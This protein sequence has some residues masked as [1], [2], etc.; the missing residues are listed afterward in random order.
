MVEA[1]LGDCNNQVVRMDKPQTWRKLLGNCI[2]DPHERQRIASELGVNP[3]TLTRWVKHETDPHPQTL[4]RLLTVLPEHRNLLLELINKEFAGFS[5]VMRDTV[6]RSEMTSIPSE[7]Y[8]R[9]LHTLTSTPK[10]LL[11]QVLCTMLLE[12]ALKH[13]DPVRLGMAIIVARCMPPSENH[14][15]R[16]LR[17][18]AGRGSS[19]WRNDLEK[20][21]VLL[22]AESLVGHAVISCHLEVNQYLGDEQS[23]APGYRD[24][25]E[26]SAVAAAIMHCGGIAG[27]LLVS[28]TRPQYFVPAYCALVEQYAELFALAFAP[29]DFYNPQDIELGLLPPAEAQQPYFSGFPQRILQLMSRGAAGEPRPITYQQAEQLAWQQI[30][31]ELLRV[32]Q[33]STE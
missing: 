2:N 5:T 11:F 3:L 24:S 33:Q 12:Q 27:C 32:S 29:E 15:V 20:E 28:S 10:T 30:E 31:A 25:W 19:P 13:L 1:T 7:F 18:Y 14:K 8:S 9:V 23:W 26:E 4:R 6:V 16:S 22:G 17:E 21:A